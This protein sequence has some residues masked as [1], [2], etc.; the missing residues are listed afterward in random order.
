M[1]IML[2]V[3]F[4]ASSDIRKE[5][6]FRSKGIIFATMAGI[7]IV[8][9]VFS[10]YLA[11]KTGIF[12]KVV[13]ITSPAQIIFGILLGVLLASDSLSSKQIIGIILSVVGMY[14]VVIK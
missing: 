13:A 12:S 1:L 5:L 8:I 11:L 14:L 9:G 3:F 4:L 6:D 7:T 2:T 10:N